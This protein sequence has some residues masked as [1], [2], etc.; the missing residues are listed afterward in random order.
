MPSSESVQFLRALSRVL[1]WIYTLAWSFSFYPQLLLNIRRRSTVGTTPSF[2][3]LNIIG[4]LC[5]TISTT[6]FYFS[7]VIQRQYRGRH[8]GEDN[9]VRLN[10]VAFATHAFLI[11]LL[12]LSQF[13]SSLWK[14]ERRRW[15]VGKFVWGVVFGSLV[16]VIWITGLVLFREQNGWEWLDIVSIYRLPHDVRS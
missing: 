5:Y 1:G 14:F 8:D 15:G 13:W 6:A 9:T 3:I 16:S 7:P 4:F 12:L 11:S 10:D 2:P